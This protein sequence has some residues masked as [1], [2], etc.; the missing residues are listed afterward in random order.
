[1]TEQA[2]IQSAAR[3]LVRAAGDGYALPPFETGF[4]GCTAEGA[5]P[6][7]RETAEL[8][9]KRGGEE[10]SAGLAGI[11]KVSTGTLE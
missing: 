2:D 10:I 11:G 9:M 8:R 3:G 1:M 4:P 7:Q 6:I 5:Y